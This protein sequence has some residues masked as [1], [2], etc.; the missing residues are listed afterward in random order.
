MRWRAA[1]APRP[2]PDR[3][4]GRWG[5]VVCLCI[6]V[7]GTQLPKPCVRDPQP[8]GLGAREDSATSCSH[9]VWTLTPQCAK[10][11][12]LRGTPPARTAGSTAGIPAACIRRGAPPTSYDDWNSDEDGLK[13]WLQAA[14]QLGFGFTVQGF[15]PIGPDPSFGYVELSLQQPLLAS[16]QFPIKVEAGYVEG[17]ADPG[18]PEGVSARLW[19]H[20]LTGEHPVMNDYENK[21]R[22]QLTSKQSAVQVVSPTTV[23][24]TLEQL[25]PFQ[26]RGRDEKLHPRILHNL[27]VHVRLDVHGDGNPASHGDDASMI[28]P[29]TKSGK[30]WVRFRT[31]A[32]GKMQSSAATSFENKYVK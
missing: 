11:H 32:G 26:Y 31:T 3:V 22:T 23:R 25:N 18:E 2:G 20:Q 8:R 5:G 4:S 21:Y 24:L 15:T 17:G 13:T 1:C 6:A 7:L 19:L 12:G 27:T 14:G 28:V 30:S 16:T 29:T 10:E 9:T